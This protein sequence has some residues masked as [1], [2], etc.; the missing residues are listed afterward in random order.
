MPQQRLQLTHLQKP[1]LILHYLYLPYLIKKV[2]RTLQ[3]IPLKQLL[4]LLYRHNKLRKVDLPRTI[5]V[6]VVDDLADG[7]L[8]VFLAVDL[9][10]GEEKLGGLDGA[11]VVFV[12]LAELLGE[13]A[14]VL[15][16]DGVGCEVGLD[17]GDEFVFELRLNEGVRRIVRG[18]LGRSSRWSWRRS[19]CIRRSI[20]GLGLV[21]RRY[22]GWG[23]W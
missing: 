3:R 20:C 13:D 19:R 4:P 22:D 6:D 7:L 15:L 21:T 2:K 23:L 12:D 1:R 17:Y 5:R 18:F 8:G 11:G 10:E 16:G 14:A 9:F